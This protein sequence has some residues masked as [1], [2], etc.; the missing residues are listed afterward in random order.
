V[1][2]EILQE[3]GGVELVGIVDP[4]PERRSVLGLPHLGS[5]D[6]LPALARDGI[7]GAVA[8]VGD[9]LVR[10]AAF[11][12]ILAAGLRPVSAIHP[13]ATVSRS[14]TIGRGVVIM[15]HA[16]L[17]ALCRIG[18]NAIVNTGAT[19]D[20]HGR[21]GGHAHVAPG[22]HLAGNVTLGDASFLGTG[23]NVTP[24]VTIGAGVF[25][26]AGLTVTRDVPAHTRLRRPRPVPAIPLTMPTA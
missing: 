13:R 6:D 20:H 26:S 3:A 19:I 9:N 23:V 7:D 8:A 5:D 17:N 1:V 4:G 2:I 12:R 14:V 11:E 24:G 16:V 22:C 10:R 15:A 21:I 25:V 18:D